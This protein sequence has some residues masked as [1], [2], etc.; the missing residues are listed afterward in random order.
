MLTEIKHFKKIISALRKCSKSILQKTILFCGLFILSGCTN[1]F[2]LY[3]VIDNL[4]NIIDVISSTRSRPSY[5]YN[6]SVE[7]THE[8]EGLLYVGGSFSVVG[9]CTGQGLVFD[10]TTAEPLVPYGTAPKILGTINTSISDNQGGFYVGGE[11]TSAN[12]VKANGLVHILSDGTIDPNFQSPHI[13]SGG[14]FRSLAFDSSNGLLYA[15]GAFKMRT[16]TFQSDSSI[17][18][19]NQ[20]TGL[21]VASQP[22]IDSQVSA[23]VSDGAGGFYFFKTGVGLQH[24][25][26]T[27]EIDLAFGS[28][29]IV[30]TNGDIYTIFL[31]GTTLYAGGYFDM[32]G[33]QNRNHARA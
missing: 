33:G 2:G 22:K 16:G 10:S 26:T 17:G 30:S 27:G 8:N 1:P 18:I 11:I 31:S 23:S 29:G 21:L 25:L 6:G 5:C 24:I 32:I 15:G 4:S 7:T 28:N 9:A 3:S 13:D 14:Y 19:F 20:S 12:G